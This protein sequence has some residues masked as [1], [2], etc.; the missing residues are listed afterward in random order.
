VGLLTFEVNGGKQPCPSSS[1]TQESRVDELLEWAPLPQDK[2]LLLV[3]VFADEVCD[4][5]ECRRLM[6]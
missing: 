1:H 5:P 3:R 4:F 6:S 2:V